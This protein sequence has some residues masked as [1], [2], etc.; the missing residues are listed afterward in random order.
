MPECKPA[1]FSAANLRPAANTLLA[2][3]AAVTAMRIAH[4][5][6][7][8]ILSAAAEA[9]TVFGYGSLPAAAVAAWKLFKPGEQ[10]DA[11]PNLKALAEKLAPIL[12]S[13]QE[14]P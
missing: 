10:S 5:D 1:R 12:Q 11:D 4:F 7:D 6:L 2:A 3:V 13:Q 8:Q 14:Q 9:A